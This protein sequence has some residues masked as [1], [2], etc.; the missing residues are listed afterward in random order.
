MNLTRAE[1]FVST[2]VFFQIQIRA[3][4]GQ[5]VSTEGGFSHQLAADREDP[6]AS[7]TFILHRVGED[8]VLLQAATGAFVRA[9]KSGRI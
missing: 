8:K 9:T 2:F 4:N 7:E 6:G 3:W 5:Y 1:I